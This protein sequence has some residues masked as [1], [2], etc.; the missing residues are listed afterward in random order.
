MQATKG[1]LQCKRHEA[2]HLELP[3]AEVERGRPSPEAVRPGSAVSWAAFF[4]ATSSSLQQASSLRLSDP[5]HMRAC[6]GQ[7]SQQQ[8]YVAASGEV[9]ISS[10]HQTSANVSPSS[11]PSEQWQMPFTVQWISDNKHI[12]TSPCSYDSKLHRQAHS[13][14]VMSRP[15]WLYRGLRDTP[16]HSRVLAHLAVGR[17]AGSSKPGGK[18]LPLACAAAG[19]R[20]SMTEGLRSGCLSC[21]LSR[22]ACTLHSRPLLGL[23][24]C[25]EIT[26]A[27]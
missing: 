5:A 25:N 27:D 16:V 1:R 20:R 11:L 6:G 15:I 12:L 19:V 17:A 24:T 22:R 13:S 7:L 26:Q 23:D 18:P 2:A 9:D 21:S 10:G 8:P 3:G 14:V 4:T